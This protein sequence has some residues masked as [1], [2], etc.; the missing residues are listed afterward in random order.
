M[1]RFHPSVSWHST[2]TSPESSSQKTH[3]ADQKYGDTSSTGFDPLIADSSHRTFDL[4]NARSDLRSPQTFNVPLNYE[5]NYN[6]PLIVWLH[7]DGFN[8]NQVDHV[9]PHISTRNY[10]AT[11]IR[12]TRAMDSVGHQFQWHATPSSIDAAHEK[13]LCAIDEISDRYSVHADRIVLAGYRSGGT[14]AMRL[15]FRD[16]TRFAGVI[17]LGGR[18]PNGGRAYGDL[19]AIRARKLPMLWQ[20][21]IESDSFREN[22]LQEDIG[23]AQLLHAK[24]DVR[25]YNDDDEMNTVALS[26][27]NAWIMNRVVMGQPLSADEAIETTPV[28]F[29]DN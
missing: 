21:A 28:G 5:P 8:E 17:S 14:M 22:D 23:Q 20:Y 6:Y 9:M 12:G 1:S 2:S 16:P 19:N 13:V 11:G 25:K 24:V 7:S 26:D 15:A 10:L 4:Q 29:S 18:I 27:I 3:A